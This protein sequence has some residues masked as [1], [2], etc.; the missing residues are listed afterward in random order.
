MSNKKHNSQVGD[1]ISF[2][3]LL[4]ISIKSKKLIIIVTLF[5]TLFA[6]ALNMQKETIYESSSYYQIG[7]Y[8][9]ENEQEILIEP[10][11]RLINELD[12][13]LIY[14]QGF[15]SIELIEVSKNILE[16]RFASNLVSQN[17]SVMNDIFNY[18][19]ER[20]ANLKIIKIK[21]INAKIDLINNEIDFQK[22]NH[23]EDIINT[24][25]NIDLQI[26]N[27]QER[28]IALEEVIKAETSNLNLLN[29]VPQNKLMR[30]TQTLTTLD[31][32]IY[33]HKSEL[34]DKK[35]E[36]KMLLDE[37]V[38]LQEKLNKSENKDYI[39]NSSIEI[40]D[41]I[42]ER[43]K[44]EDQLNSLS[45]SVTQ[46]V[47][48]TLTNKINQSQILLF[49]GFFSGLLMSITFIAIRSNFQRSK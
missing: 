34:S 48:P 22:N 30:L 12:I 35:T 40:F 37:K 36:L 15:D 33:S 46:L 19:K 17:T 16:V 1:E 42:R 29:S 24:M 7:T 21:K 14:K 25:K 20:H 45:S 9:D 39:D 44:Y 5:T 3:E 18:I 32:V 4:E 41:L 2:K 23:K 8:V 43:N 6:F 31:Q 28:I 26:P 13:E 49:V 10:I 38:S 47:K 27:Y 11:E